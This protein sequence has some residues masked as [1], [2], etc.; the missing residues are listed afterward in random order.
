MTDTLTYDSTE[1]D[2]PELT[3][4]E[5]DSLEVG[6]KLAEQ[7]EQLLAGKYKNAE[8]LEKAYTELEKKL[9]SKEEDT[10]EESEEEE[11]E[12]TT[13]E[14]DEESEPSAE[15]SLLNEANKEYWDND[16]KLSDETIEKFSSMSSKDLVSAYLEVTKGIPQQP[17]EA[18]VAQADIN[19]I[20]NSVGG[21]KAY[22]DMI[23][24]ASNS[25]DKD[26]IK[27][28]DSTVN[29][30]NVQMIKLA[31]AGLKAQYEND[32]G[33]E[34]RMLS[35]KAAKTSGDVFR[36]QA[37]VVRAMSDP[38]YDRDPA[39]RNDIYEKLDRSDLK[40]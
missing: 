26:A 6:E 34:G 5:Q 29:S 13:S 9:G 40:F 8:E 30:G 1:A 16:G 11:V 24:W 12:K 35:G 22:K 27:A 4:D 38:R 33:Y 28:F 25:L 23:Q 14:D 37:E 3:P 19:S 21:Q 36:S 39:Y 31:V 18:E 20:Q 7:E 2:A 17:T 15:V 10:A 32:N